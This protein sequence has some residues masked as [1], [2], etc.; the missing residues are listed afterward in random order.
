MMGTIAM[1]ED[2]G[3]SGTEASGDVRPRR[4]WPAAETRLNVLESLAP[5]A[6]VSRAAR[7]HEVNAN[8]V[9][10]WRKL[11]RDGRLGCGGLV[12]V[13]VVAENRPSQHFQKRGKE[14]FNGSPDQRSIPSY[15]VLPR[16]VAGTTVPR[17][18]RLPRT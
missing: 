11:Y 9:F 14:P 17:V 10:A 8:Q 16:P 2:E 15:R 1:S 5:G 12:P 6:S 7:R 4:R 18:K 3:L 13:T